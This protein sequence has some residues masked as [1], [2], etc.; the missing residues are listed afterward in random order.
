[1]SSSRPGEPQV[2][3]DVGYQ[4]RRDFARFPRGATP[5]RPCQPFRAVRA[6]PL[7]DV[8]KTREECRCL[9]ACSWR[10]RLAPRSRA[11][12]R[13][14]GPRSLACRAKAQF[15]VIR[16]ASNFWFFD[17]PI[18]VTVLANGAVRRRAALLAP[19]SARRSSTGLQ[20]RRNDEHTPD[21]HASP[22][23]ATP[24]ALL[25]AGESEIRRDPSIFECSPL[26]P[27]TRA[28]QKARSPARHRTLAVHREI[29]YAGIILRIVSYTRCLAIFAVG[30]GVAGKHSQTM[31][32]KGVGAAECNRS[33]RVLRRRGQRE[34]CQSQC[35]AG[36]LHR[37]VCLW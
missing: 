30:T 34:R 31:V 2:A 14:P 35:D 19:P 10:S 20:K 17:V 28:H 23:N 22:R 25:A 8:A 26:V 3:N 4:D 15:G 1:L 11:G 5:P 37:W 29:E 9:W 36:Q 24:A 27:S 13:K 18:F 21:T 12:A 32:A 33:S 7:G 6:K 16:V